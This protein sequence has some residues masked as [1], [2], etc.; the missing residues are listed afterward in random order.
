VAEVLP[1]SESELQLL[2]SLI[3]HQVCFLV[4]GRNLLLHGTVTVRSR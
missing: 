3:R 2:E 1:L 4:V